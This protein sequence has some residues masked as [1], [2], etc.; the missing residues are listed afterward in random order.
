MIGIALVS[1]ASIFAASADSTVS[2]Y[3]DKG[4][5][6]DTVVQNQ[7]GFSAFSPD[8]A[9]TV[10]RVP[11]V[12][13]VSAIRFG[14]GRIEGQKKKVDITGI[15]PATFPGLWHLKAGGDALG[16]LGPGETVVKKG[17]ADDHDIHV[18]QTLVVR[19]A[20]RTDVRLRVIGISDDKAGLV[21]KLAVSAAVAERDFSIT[22]DTYLFVGFAP[23]ADPK[24]TKHAMAGVLDRAFPQTEVLT[25]EEFKQNQ[26]DQINQI[27]GM[28]YALL[29]LAIIVS[30]FGIV[31]TLVLSI[32]ER[33]R[34]L[35]MLRAIGT[36]R[37]QLKRMI[38]YE[39]VITA[40]I[41]GVLGLVLGVVLSLLFTQALDDFQLSVPVVE[42]IVLLVLSALAGMLAAALPARRA[43]KLDVLEALAYE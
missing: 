11:G 13:T 35:G 40:T 15:D 28:I 33:T 22:Q 43:A 39:S 34:E 4:F 2:G 27:L 10:K 37:R 41:G 23:G 20:S 36:S 29:A 3:V 24:A 12:R 25:A 16:R 1:F 8:A 32:T 14:Q 9:E 26:A 31:N 6:G 21:G 19:T 17:F 7:D 18:G 30:L 42:L 5:R 38:R